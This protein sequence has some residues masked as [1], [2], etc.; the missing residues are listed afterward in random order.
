M[1]GYK[2]STAAVIC[3]WGFIKQN[4]FGPP[5]LLQL[6]VSRG[7][8]QRIEFR[9]LHLKKN[10][11]DSEIQTRGSRKLG[12]VSAHPCHGKIGFAVFNI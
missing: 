12:L 8:T 10:T 2:H 7:E 6:F 5:R 9:T 1:R 3:F 11:F 4:S